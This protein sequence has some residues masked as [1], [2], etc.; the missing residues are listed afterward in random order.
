VTPVRRLLIL[1]IV[2]LTGAGGYV[3]GRAWFRPTERVRQPIAFNHEKHTTE[4]GIEC[5]TCHE[6]YAEGSHAGLPLLSTCMG[7]HET[8][9]TDSPEEQKIRDMVAAGQNDVFRKLFRMP[10]HVFYSH[11]RHAGIA[12]L[13]CETC[14]GSIAR[15]ASPPE[16]PFVRI[17]MNF[18]LDCHRR[19]KVRSDCTGCHR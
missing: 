13:P 6:Y 11:R 19:E 15:T 8:G 7:C 5:G 14:H 4:L 10:D 1:A 16:K 2:L 12:K 9:Q 3:I 17:N 18:C